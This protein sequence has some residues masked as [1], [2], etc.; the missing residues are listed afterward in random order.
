MQLR[1]RR[2]GDDEGQVEQQF[3]RR[4][5]AV[6][7]V[8]V[9]AGD[10]RSFLIATLAYSRSTCVEITP[11]LVQTGRA[12]NPMQRPFANSMN[13]KWPCMYLK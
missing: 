12:A 8:D 3:Q 4:G 6:R 11:L 10:K 5:D 9:A 7:F 2:D 1:R 13:I